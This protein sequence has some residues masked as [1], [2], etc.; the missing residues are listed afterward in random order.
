MPSRFLKAA[1]VA[2]LCAGALCLQGCLAVAATGAVVGTTVGVAGAVVGTTVKA[3]GAVVGAATG[4]HKKK[5]DKR[6]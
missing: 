1:A 5:V 6:K 3:G 2:A 4:G